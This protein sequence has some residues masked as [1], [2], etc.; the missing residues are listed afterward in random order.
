MITDSKGNKIYPVHQKKWTAY[1]LHL[2]DEP[3]ARK[4]WVLKWD[5]FELKRDREKNLFMKN[6]SYGFNDTFL[7]NILTPETKV[8]IKEKFRKLKLITTV[9]DILEKWTYLHFLWLWF[10]LQI[11]MPLWQFT[12]DL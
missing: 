4:L 9:W 1:Y 11:F 8:I 3:R 10:E 12:Q 6:N 5:V 2:R 7:R